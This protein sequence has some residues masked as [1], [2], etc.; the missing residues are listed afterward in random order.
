M[1]KANQVSVLHGVGD[2]R[3]DERPVPSPAPGEV[4][5]AMGSVGICGSDVH[6]L[7]H[8]RIGSFVVE[9]PMILGHESSGI[10]EALGD[11]VTSL[12]PGDRIALEPGVPCRRCAVCKSGRYNLCAEVRFFATPPVDGSMATYVTHPADFC[13]RLPDHVS[14]DEGAMMEPLS[15]GIHAC[16]RGGVSMGDRVLVMGA[17]PIGLVTVLAARA[18][19]ASVIALSDPQAERLDL[20]RQVGADL[21]TS[22]AGPGLVP[23]LVDRAGGMFDASVDC[24]GAEAAV[25]VAMNATRSGGKVVLVGLGADEMTL[26]IVESATREVDLLGIFRYC[27][28]Y[29]A[30]LELIASGRVDVKPIVTHRFSMTRV[31]E[32]FD[33][34]RTGRDG[35]VKVMVAVS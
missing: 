18:A 8:G 33:V 5:I 26:P 4:L 6:Y 22:A 3:I 20:A 11:G 35:A 32:A 15:V 10:V 16:R 25:R 19:G 21:V 31:S 7:E 28:A 1:T 17:G 29:P 9:A 23:E 13:Y 27:N 12:R 14:L 2:L 30:A 34:A 24:S